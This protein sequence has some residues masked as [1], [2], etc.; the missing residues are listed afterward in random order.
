[1]SSVQEKQV[2]PEGIMQLG[3]GFAAS[4]TL[5][6]AVELGLFTELAKQPLHA[7][8]IAERLKLHQRS[9]LDFLDT[10][11]ALRMLE[12][13][14][15]GE[16]SNTSE[17]DA[18]LDKEKP[19][20]IGGM[21]EMANQRLYP[22]WGSLTEALQTGKP[23]NEAKSGGTL[24][25]AIFGDPVRLESFLRAMTALSMGSALAIAQKFPWGRY[26]TFI[27]I[28]AAQGC[29]PVQIALATEH[30]TGA[31][32]DLPV[33]RPIFENYV[34][35]HSL[36]D[37]LKFIEGDFFNDPL[38]SADVLIMGHI[39][40]DWDLAEKQMLIRK[41]YDA[42]PKGGA[43][44]VYESFI[45]DDRREN[46]MGLLMSLNM[47]IETPGGFDYTSADC[48]Q[49]MIEAGFRETGLERLAGPESMVVGIK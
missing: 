13:N 34:R 46:A 30:L 43:L 49:W 9:T 40:H 36:E 15:H 16:Y 18:F 6:S 21:L 38:P 12:R 23:Q 44:I 5:L 22:F 17:A 1:M 32:F 19:S 8:A 35:A 20:Y 7:S 3:F 47:L 41:A 2:T 14:A 33:V 45:D 11:V 28:G 42:L 10:L 25:D 4:K 31:G 48:K 24:F 39:L 26:R 27:D 37:R 29:V